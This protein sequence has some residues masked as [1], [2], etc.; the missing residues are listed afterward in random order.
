MIK[1]MLMSAVAG[2][3]LWV[4][5]GE[6][7]RRAVRREGVPESA[8]WVL[9]VDMDALRTTEVWKLIDSEIAKNGQV[10]IK[11]GEIE[12]FTGI[13]SPRGCTTSS[14]FGLGFSEENV[15]I[16]IGGAMDQGRLIG[17][18]QLDRTSNR[19]STARRTCSPGSTRTRASGCRGRS[20]TTRRPPSSASRPTR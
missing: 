4:G 6:P 2:V 19:R 18:L 8:K 7:P 9:H 1:R 20:T 11:L 3:G 10:D 5:T 12:Q 15:V 16:V 13:S 17:F 14:I